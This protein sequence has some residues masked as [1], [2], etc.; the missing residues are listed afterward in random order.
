MGSPSTAPRTR[1]PEVRIHKAIADAGLASRRRAEALVLAGRVAV[2]GRQAE[3]GQRVDPERDAITVDGRPLAAEPEAMY[4]ALNKPAGVTSTV[5]DPHAEQTV[6]QLVPMA[7]RRQAARLYPVG[8][9]DRD[10]EGLLLITNDGE[11]AQRLLHPSYGVER[12]YAVGLREPLTADRAARLSAGIEME[13]GVA[14]L[15][16]LRR[17]TRPEDRRLDELTDEGSGGLVWYR[18]TLRQGWRRQLRRMFTAVG[19]PVARLVRIRIG[20][21][22]LEGPP[23]SSRALDGRES[24]RLAPRPP[25][26]ARG[27]SGEGLV[28][29]LDGPASSG[30]SSVGAGAASAVG[31]RFCDTGLL[32]RALTWLALERGVDPDDGPALA[33]LE[34]ELRLAEDADGR[35][36]RVLVGGRDVTADVHNERVDREVSRVARCAE[37]RA[38]LLPR[39]REIA[40][41]GGIIMAGRDIGTVVLPDADL[42]LFLEVSHA[43]RARRRAED[44]GFPEGS[45]A[46]ARLEEELRRRDG[47]DTTRTTAPLKVPDGARIIRSDGNTLEETVAAVADAVREAERGRGNR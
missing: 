31:Y 44:R 34:P 3:V 33:A 36:T 35:L 1:V 29:S 37:V 4:L 16:G 46:A 25:S 45:E 30:K 15:A 11:W 5:R 39:Q 26:A 17:Q 2:N 12:E 43:E 7:L 40:Q 22:W 24:R 20:T 47:I 19:Q 18:A 8:R 23:G 13:E 38:S 32:Y 27:A 42:K 6:V 10:S 9:L 21:L 14:R 28:V 41:G